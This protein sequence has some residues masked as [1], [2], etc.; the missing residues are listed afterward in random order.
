MLLILK[1]V[2]GKRWGQRVIDG[3]TRFFERGNGRKI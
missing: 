1:G 2:G 3:L